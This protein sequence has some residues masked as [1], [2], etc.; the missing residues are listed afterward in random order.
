MI[1]GREGEHYDLAYG[2]LPVYL[3]RVTAVLLAKAAA[4]PYLDDYHSYR[5]I[6]RS[7]TVLFSLLTILWVY[8]IGKRTFGER[9]ALLGAALLGICVLHI[10]LSHFMTVDLLMSAMNTAGL[11]FC[12]IPALSGAAS[13]HW[14]MG[15][16][17]DSALAG[18]DTGC[19]ITGSPSCSSVE[20]A[21]ASGAASILGVKP[22]AF[23]TPS[24]I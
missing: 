10:Q 7:I 20:S 12:A 21:A 18:G 19:S 11:L 9:A 23:G 13:G 6:G 5:M 3:Y 4:N 15:L 14:G 16:S 22:I 2:T 24:A 8:Q 17:R 1:P